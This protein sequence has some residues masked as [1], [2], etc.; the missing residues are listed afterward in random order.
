MA[1]IAFEKILEPLSP[2]APSGPDLDLEGDSAYWAFTSQLDV[3]LPTSYAAFDRA[4]KPVGDHLATAV[5]LLK[6]SIDLRLLVAIAKL[7]ILDLKFADFERAVA[8][9]ALLLGARWDDVHPQLTDMT[10]GM[11]FNALISLDDLPHVVMPLQDAPLFR[12]K[13]LGYVTMRMRLLS[14]GSIEARAATETQEAEK[15]PG[16]SDFRAAMDEALADEVIA[17]HQAATRLAESIAAIES[18]YAEKTGN[19]G[20]LSLPRLGALAGRIKK[21]LDQV[22]V[23][24]NLAPAALA[25]EGAGGADNAGSGSAPAH[26]ASGIGLVGPVRS[27]RDAA[28]ALAAAADYF[29]RH[30]PSSPS[31]LL[32]AQ[33]RALIGKSLFEALSVLVPE[34]APRA[35]IG[36]GR[37]FPLSLPVERL[38]T[39]LPPDEPTFDASAPDEDEATD[40][41]WDSPAWGGD[42]SAEEPAAEQDSDVG[43]D[44]DAAGQ[45]AGADAAEAFGAEGSAQADADDAHAEDGPE[46]PL[47]EDDAP[48]QADAAAEAPVARPSA[49]PT[50]AATT[51]SEAVELLAAVSTFYRSTEPSSPV[52]ALLESARANAGYDFAQVLKAVLPELYLRV[53]E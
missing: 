13:R 6:R 10:E 37:D 15:V 29:A 45:E 47:T 35:M 27:M 26:M 30:E 1:E 48:V 53:D 9:I 21:F 49:R 43:A 51:R 41:S 46:E 19:Y 4:E 33:A 28:A 52:P 14:E 12:S 20:A 8:S 22:M 34:H 18:I 17:V 31:R 50:Y 11:R 7:S 25:A 24:K 42:E 5:S 3:Y 39:L 44:S 38:V 2:E 23:A 32:L 40:N 36:L 16:E